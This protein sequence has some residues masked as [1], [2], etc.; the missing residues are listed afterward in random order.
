MFGAIIVNG[1]GCR[2]FIKE[3]SITSGSTVA[4]NDLVGWDGTN[5]R[6]DVFT[7]GIPCGIVIKGGVGNAG[8]TVKAVVNT[9][10]TLEFL[11]DNDNDTTTFG[12]THRGKYF[13]G[14]G[15]TGA[16]QVDTSTQTATRADLP[17]KCLEYNPQGYED[18]AF[19]TDTSIGLFGFWA[20]FYN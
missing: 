19:D 10:P 17:Y 8:G 16:Q 1:S 14:V 15:G 13:S 6:V 4:K 7:T 9:D 12:A 11:M 3:L 5:G 2:N 20:H 18:G